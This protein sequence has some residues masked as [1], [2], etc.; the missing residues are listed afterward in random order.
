MAAQ[1]SGLQ[2]G[3]EAEEMTRAELAEALDQLETSL[4]RAESGKKDVDLIVALRIVHKIAKDR[5]K[6]IDKN[7]K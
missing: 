3:K 4:V 1:A 7:G 6:E 5:L 2:D